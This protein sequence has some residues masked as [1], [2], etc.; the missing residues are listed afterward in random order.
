MKHGRPAQRSFRIGHGGTLDA[1]ASGVLVV[2][3]GRG[4][5]EL[6][7]YLTGSKRYVVKA[8][9]G[10]RTRSLDFA[11]PCEMACDWR[12]VTH[13]MVA[14]LLPKYRGL[15]SQKTPMYS[16]KSV[17]GDRLYKLALDGQVVE[18][19]EKL[20]NVFHLELTAFEPPFFSLS[21]ESSSGFYVRQLVADLGNEFLVFAFRFSTS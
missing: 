7:S 4:C 9:L 1:L 8:Q 11:T 16:A 13:E 17:K 14:A 19:A 5:A 6:Q 12:S 3:I 18:R 20:L 21:I 15:I 2:G 10:A